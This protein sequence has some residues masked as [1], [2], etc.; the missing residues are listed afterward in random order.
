MLPTLLICDDDRIFQVGAKAALSRYFKCLSANHCDE[1]L[2]IIKNNSVQI[3]LLDVHMRN[4]KEGLHY[5]PKL[6]EVDPDLAII[7]NS[8]DNDFATVREA[9]RL[10][11][12]DYIPK[13]FDP[14]E[15][16][17]SLNRVTERQKLL[18]T[19]QKLDFEARSQNRHFSLVG[20]GKWY[21]DILRTLEKVRNSQANVIITGE[22]GTGKR[23]HR[24]PTPKDSKI[25]SFRTLCNSGFSDHSKLNRR[26]FALRS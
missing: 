19:Q 26:K 12:I 15:M 6:L 22:T 21:T 20:K 23:S 14:E 7:M 25:R 17:H 3:L 24:S 8:Q 9:M 11:A 16:I 2:E 5:I 1:A 10:G 4:P 13:Q 18:K